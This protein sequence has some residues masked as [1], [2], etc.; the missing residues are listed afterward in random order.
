MPRARSAEVGAPPL[1]A[2]NA[3]RRSRYDRWLGG[4]CGGIAIYTVLPVAITAWATW[5]YP[6]RVVQPG[7]TGKT[8]SQTGE[9]GPGPAHLS[10]SVLRTFSAPTSPAPLRSA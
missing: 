9:A 10:F 5:Q 7:A 3:L 4:V 8:S 6:S 1:R 2:I